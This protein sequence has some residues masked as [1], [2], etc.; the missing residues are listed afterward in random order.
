MYNNLYLFCV[1]NIKNNK[2]IKILIYNSELENY[3]EF[4]NIE[5]VFNIGQK[6][7]LYN[8]YKTLD[9]PIFIKKEISERINYF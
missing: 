9:I 4:T 6:N 1:Y 7:G 8:D 5:W 3:F 2:Y